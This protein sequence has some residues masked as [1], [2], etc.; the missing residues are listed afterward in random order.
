M[1][2]SAFGYEKDSKMFFKIK[3]TCL[4]LTANNDMKVLSVG[5][6]ALI[7]ARSSPKMSFELK[8]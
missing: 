6:K 2:T 4:T 1:V 8:A 5:P 7:C 3:M